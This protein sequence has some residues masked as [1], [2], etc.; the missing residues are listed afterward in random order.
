MDPVG[1][2]LTVTVGHDPDGTPVVT[3]DGQ[4]DLATAAS[5]EEA[6]AALTSPDAGGPTDVVVDMTRLTFMDSSGITVL[7]V[8]ANRGHTLRLRAP[9][10]LIRNL[11]AA[12]GLDETLPI[13]R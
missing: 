6:F 10:G 7:L 1:A 4:L 8:A 5:A 12:T 2:T 13:E 9:S 3:L 11:I